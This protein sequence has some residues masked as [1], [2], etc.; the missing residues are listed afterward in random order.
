MVDAATLTREE[1]EK[2][3]K[4]ICADMER[5]SPVSDLTVKEHSGT[6]SEET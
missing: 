3:L 1:R 5:T 2:L 6:E 4:E